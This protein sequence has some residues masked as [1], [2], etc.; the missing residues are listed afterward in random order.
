MSEEELKQVLAAELSESNKKIMEDMLRK[1]FSMEEI[2]EHFQN[3]VES[4]NSKSELAR[5]IKKLSSG[6]KLSN[7]DMIEL[8]KDQLGGNVFYYAGSILGL[9]K[10]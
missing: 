4:R 3:R 6:R 1:G 10:S 9:V 5:K 7:E 2:L 8:I